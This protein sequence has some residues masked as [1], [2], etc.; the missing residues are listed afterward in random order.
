MP[1]LLA[2]GLDET[3]ARPDI[4]M[5]SHSTLEL[6]VQIGAEV[7]SHY[8]ATASLNF[9]GITWRPELR[10]TDEITA[11]LA[12]DA[13][14]AAME[15]QNV[16]TLFGKEFVNIE[17]FLSGAEAKVG[18]YLKDL[19]R[20]AEWHE[21]LLTGLVAGLDANEQA[22]Q[23]TI[24][25]DTHSGLSVGPF[26]AIRRLCQAEYKSFE[27]GRPATDPPTCDKTLN[28]AGGCHGRW[29]A[30]EKFTRHMGAP[31]LDN[32]VFQQII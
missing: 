1:R 31:F 13:S 8:L 32:R 11:N 10:E 26:R 22:V 15:I 2:A 5:S 27:C 28:G 23:L 17:E 16:D 20:G 6:T 25:S 9:G 21:V 7:R 4:Q 29:G 14:E 19:D 3:L 18:E 12:A 24:I 30:I